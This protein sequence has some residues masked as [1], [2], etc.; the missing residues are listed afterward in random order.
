MSA[1]TVWIAYGSNQDN[2][3]AQLAR[4]R[5]ALRETRQLKELAASSLY[6]SPPFGLTD[7]PDF[8]NAVVGYQTTLEPLAILCLM[9]ETERQLGRVRGVKNGPRIID[10]DVLLIDELIIDSPELT[11]P[12]PRMAERAFVLLPLA[13]IDANIHI[14]SL[15][16]VQEALHLL[17]TAKIYRL[18]YQP[19]QTL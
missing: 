7:Q 17:D 12:H 1:H 4:A 6:R 2:P 15:G 13:E 9:L 16:R 11:V 10:L 8:I 19:W 18:E 14:P 3:C 5:R